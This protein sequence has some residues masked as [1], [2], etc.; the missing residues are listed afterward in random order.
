MI[1]QDTRLIDLTVAQ[2]AEVIDQ[3]VKE[4]LQRNSA[5]KTELHLVYGIK[6]IVSGA[7]ELVNITL[8]ERKYTLEFAHGKG[9]IT[10]PYEEVRGFE[11]AGKDRVFY[12]ANAKLAGDKIVVD[13]PQEVTEA[14]SLRYS[15]SDCPLTSNVMSRF[16]FPLAPFRTDSWELVK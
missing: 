10:P 13:V 16:G 11:I 15:F 6:G 9:L 12:P 2:L 4:S 1:S 14:Q 3:A 5:Q 7:P 8:S